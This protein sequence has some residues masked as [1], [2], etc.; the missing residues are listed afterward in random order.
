MALIKSFT[1][2]AITGVTTVEIEFDDKQTSIL[3]AKIDPTVEG[4]ENTFTDAARALTVWEAPRMYF[5]G[6]SLHVLP[7]R[8]N[9]YEEWDWV[10]HSWMDLRTLDVAKAQKW[11]EMKVARDNAM[12]SDLSTPFGSFDAN[13][14]A[15]K[16]ITDAVL[17][18]QTLA[19]IG[20][21]VDIGFTLAD[22]SSIT[23]TTTQMVQVGLLL[24]QRTQ[25]VYSQG[26]ILRDAI[27]AA[28]DLVTVQ[29]I[30]WG[31]T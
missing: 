25:Q 23:L 15:Q 2:D 30:T 22:N 10:S 28:T 26:R 31:S 19:S 17:L 13:A 20:E 16:S 27:N 7:D 8:P 4:Q 29:A 14:P 11:S 21:S 1:T 24:G 3:A 12:R 9:P 5:S 18:V 6:D